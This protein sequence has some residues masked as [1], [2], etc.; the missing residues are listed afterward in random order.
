MG[1]LGWA[2]AMF[3]RTLR[4]NRRGQ[5]TEKDAKAN[6][7]TWSELIFFPCWINSSHHLTYNTLQMVPNM[8]WLVV[9]N[10]FF[11]HNIWDVILPID[12]LIVFKMVIAPPTNQPV[13]I[14]PPTPCVSGPKIAWLPP[15]IRRKSASFGRRKW[16]RWSWG[17]WAPRTREPPLVGALVLWNHGMDY[18][19][20][21]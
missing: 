7:M 16:C 17:P 18:P 11:S 8:C 14:F 10:M 20:V 13:C 3:S 12:E 15:E 21:N 9:S 5:M 6:Q 1:E 2:A 4:S 19:L